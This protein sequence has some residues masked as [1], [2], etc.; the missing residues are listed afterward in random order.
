MPRNG[1]GFRIVEKQILNVRCHADGLLGMVQV[2]P[3]P[4]SRQRDSERLKSVSRQF[5]THIHFEA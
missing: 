2:A 3:C 4:A 5:G 1:Y